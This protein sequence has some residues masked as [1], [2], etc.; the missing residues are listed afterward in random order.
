MTIDTSNLAS[1]TDDEVSQAYTALMVEAERRRTLATAAQQV[2]AINAAVFAAEGIK[3]GDEWRQP[4]G[5]HNA[6]RKG[7]IVTHQ[8]KTWESTTPANVWAPGASGWREKVAEGAAPPAFVQPTGA[9]DVYAKGAKV[10]FEGA[11]WESTIDNNAYSPS[12]YPQGWK[13]LP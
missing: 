11:I 4:T 7:A 6:Y 2:D 13:R 3:D 1:L 8:G 10:T 9:H 5:A 12:E